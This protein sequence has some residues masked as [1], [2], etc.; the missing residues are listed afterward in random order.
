M[1]FFEFVFSSLCLIF[2]FVLLLQIL[3]NRSERQA[4]RYGAA[5]D[6]RELQELRARVAA[7]EAIVTDG[8][9]QL[10]REIDA[11]EREPRRTSAGGY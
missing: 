9:S 3:K 5:P 11:L 2:G 6:D 10:S 8:R 1:G 4:S 7:L